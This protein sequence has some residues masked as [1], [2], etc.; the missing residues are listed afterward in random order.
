MGL[1]IAQTAGALLVLAAFLAAQADRTS[2][3]AY[4][5][6]LANLAGSAAM[7]VTAGL[8]EEWGFLFLE[9]VW[10]VVSTVG[11]A[12]RLRDSGRSQEAT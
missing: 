9:A 5:Y 12:G 4:G 3:R 11:L 2:E 6:L 8:A 7:A 1:Q 10:A